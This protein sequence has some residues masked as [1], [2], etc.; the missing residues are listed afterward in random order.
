M[1]KNNVGFAAGIGQTRPSYLSPL[2][3]LALVEAA[4]ELNRRA[5]E[6]AEDDHE[7]DVA[8]DRFRSGSGSYVLPSEV[9]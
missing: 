6:L 5:A 7:D 3:L 8:N 9:L 4:R 1:R 2:R